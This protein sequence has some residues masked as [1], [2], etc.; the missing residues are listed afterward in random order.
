MECREARA[1]FVLG[2]LESAVDPDER[3]EVPTRTGGEWG[4]GKFNVCHLSAYEHFT[5]DIMG[6]WGYTYALSL[7]WASMQCIHSEIEIYVFQGIVRYGSKW[8]YLF[9]SW[10]VVWLCG[11]W[12]ERRSMSNLTAAWDSGIKADYSNTCDTPCTF[13]FQQRDN[14]FMVDILQFAIK[15]DSITLLTHFLAVV[16]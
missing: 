1:A 2:K 12:T 7:A 5:Q 6:D 15:A 4:G 8:A 10:E 14:H 16:A 3:P 9:T 11:K 13:L